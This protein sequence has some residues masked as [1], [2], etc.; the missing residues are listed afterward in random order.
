MI[1]RES[2]V[3]EYYQ[4]YLTTGDRRFIEAILRHNVS[5]LL[6][7]A[8]LLGLLTAPGIA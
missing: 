8:G 3:G 2:Q 5:D 1:S 7:M 4:A 6:A